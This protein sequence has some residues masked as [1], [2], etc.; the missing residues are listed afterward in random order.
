MN[1]LTLT[2]API[3]LHPTPAGYVCY[4]DDAEAAGPIL[5]LAVEYDDGDFCGRVTVR[6][7]RLDDA[8]AELERSGERVAF[9]PPMVGRAA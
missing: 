1:A 6:G 2:P 9:V 3:H 8:V 4:G 5:G 7:D